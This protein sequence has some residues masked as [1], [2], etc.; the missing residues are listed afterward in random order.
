MGMK[1]EHQ[2]MPVEKYNTDSSQKKSISTGTH[3]EW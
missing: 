2:K 1:T 3:H